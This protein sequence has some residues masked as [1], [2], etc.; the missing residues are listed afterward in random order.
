MRV[1]TRNPSPRVAWRNVE[2]SRPVYHRVRADVRIPPL[3]VLPLLAAGALQLGCAVNIATE[4]FIQHDRKQ[5][6]VSGVPELTLTTFDGEI[7]I[8][9][10]D[11]STVEVEIEKRALS[12]ELV[13]SVE[14]VAEQ[15]G[16]KIRVEARRP[17]SGTWSVNLMRG[18]GRTVRLVAFVPLH[19]N[20]L[21]QSGDG[22]ISAERVKGQLE[23]RT[24][25]GSVR[26]IEV[27]GTVH[28][29]TGDGSVKMDMV[30]GSVDVRTGDGSITLSGRPEALKL[31]SEDG[32]M[33]IRVDDGAAMT[34][35]WDLSTND[36]RVS[37]YLPRQF[38]AEL[39][40]VTGDGRVRSDLDV[41][42]QREHQNR[43]LR[44]RIGEGG[45]SLK[46]R[47]AD[48]SITLRPS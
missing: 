44:G 45:H 9:G 20:V 22:R 23:L 8:R 14:I 19:T 15:D 40:A 34:A 43:E 46:I 24:D 2:A 32:S 6:T 10:W 26:G 38:S 29:V 21:A 30:D 39:D 33:S 17:S 25:D 28:V 35:D 5:F 1:A 47:T 3:L 4:G 31:H 41:Q 11:R 37:V 13:D 12:R 16:D 48:G 27:G 36:G 18:P 42:G 7:E